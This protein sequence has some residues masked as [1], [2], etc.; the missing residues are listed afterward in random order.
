MVALD[1]IRLR[2]NELCVWLKKPGMQPALRD[3][4]S[5]V[6]IRL[7]P[8]EFLRHGASS[9][10]AILLSLL[11]FYMGCRIKPNVAVT[12]V[13]SLVG[14]VLPIGKFVVKARAAF[15]YGAELVVAPAV[16][17]SEAKAGLTS[18]ELSKVRFVSHVAELLQYTIEGEVYQVLVLQRCGSQQADG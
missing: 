17:E 13:V 15:K 3:R 11:K 2:A 8:L 6:V 14:W 9:G 4:S 12:G 1:F 7:I 16:N 5:D 10:V 18:E